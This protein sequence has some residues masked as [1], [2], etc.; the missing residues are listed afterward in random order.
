MKS[1]PPRNRFSV[2]LLK[3]GND[4]PPSR[5]TAEVEPEAEIVC[6]ISTPFDELPVFNNFNGEVWRD[7]QFE[8]E[9]KPCGTMIEFAAYYRGQRQRPVVINPPR[10]EENDSSAPQLVSF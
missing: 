10:V 2:T 5:K 6:T 8:V 9:M 4:N 1:P 3:C 7:V